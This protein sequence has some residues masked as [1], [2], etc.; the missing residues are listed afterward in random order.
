MASTNFGALTEN[1]LRVWS[2]TFWKEARNKTF[3]MSFAGSSA[4][5]MVQRITELRKTVDGDRAVITLVNEA[6]G[7]GVVGDNQLEGNEEALSQDE[8]VIKMDQWR[9]AHKNAGKMNDQRSIVNFREAA[10]DQLSYRVSDVIDQLAFL[11]LSGVA[12]TQRPN[13]AV[14]TNSQLP[15]LAYASDVVAPSSRRH[16]RWDATDG[17]VAGSTTDVAAVDLPTWEML[18][19][20]KAKAVNEYIRPL[21]SD[22]GVECYNVF[23]TPDGIAALKKDKDFLEAW[24]HA[25]KRGDENPLFKGTRHG[26]KRGIYIDGLNILEYRHVYSPSNWGG[27]SVRG[28][29]VL[30]CGAQAL[31]FADFGTPEW[32]EKEFDYGNVLGISVSKIFGLLKPQL[33]STYAQSKQDFGVMC[34][35]T[36]L[37]A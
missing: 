2:K 29:R 21:R 35:D 13:G 15:L 33:F 37:P 23:M 24:Q 18:V 19:D 27:G 20:M 4:N 5:S 28:Q 11:T 26:G 25:Q 3:I 14:R 17:L 32:D 8:M 22:D 10:K 7:D 36:G 16:Y 9:H 31:A 1:Q 34:V 30:L 12:Y 6:T